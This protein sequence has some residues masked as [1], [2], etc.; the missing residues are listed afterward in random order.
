MVVKRQVLGSQ[1]GLPRQPS[2]PPQ[3]HCSPCSTMPLPHRLP[4]MVTTSLLLV[5]QFVLTLLRPMAEQMLPM[6]HAENC[7]MPL[8]VDGF[9]MK[10]CRASHEVALR[11]QHCCRVAVPSLHELDVQSCTAPKVWPVSW[12]MTCH[13]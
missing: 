8:P 12:A 7:V 9:M 2:G 1:H 10:R 4:V 6:L 3:S 5:R 11:G 13:S